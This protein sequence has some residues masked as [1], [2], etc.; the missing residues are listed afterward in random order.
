M[1]C[2]FVMQFGIPVHEIGHSLGMWHEQMRSDRDD[3]IQI[4]WE[5]VRSRYRSQFNKIGTHNLVQ[6][7]YGSVMH[8]GARVC[9]HNTHYKM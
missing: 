9:S 2:W 1:Q 7:N 3:Y 6:Y 5:N 8:Y 4:N